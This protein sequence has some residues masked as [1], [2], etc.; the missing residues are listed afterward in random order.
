LLPTAAAAELK[1]GSWKFLEE[2]NSG[3]LGQIPIAKV[4]FDPTRRKKLDALVLDAFIT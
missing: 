3:P 2:L 1:A 4:K